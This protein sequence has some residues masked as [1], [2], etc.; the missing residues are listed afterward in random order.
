MTAPEASAAAPP[1]ARPRVSNFLLRKPLTARR[2]ARI[3]A[4]VTLALTIIGGVLIHFTDKQN[5]PNIGD[6]L[7]WAIQTVTTVGYGDAVPTSTEGQIVAALVM[8]GGISFLAIVTAAIT[9]MFIENA[10]RRIEGTGTDALSAKL[11]Q[12]GVRLD[13]IEVALKDIGAHNRDAPQ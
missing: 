10:R 7:W 9:S 3:I 8:L 5:F 4:S 1:P 11:D 13:V 12:I 2:A 6:G